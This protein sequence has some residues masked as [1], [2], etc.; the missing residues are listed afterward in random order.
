MI[1]EAIW[2]S[3]APQDFLRVDPRLASSREVNAILALIRFFPEMGSP[4]GGSVEVRRALVG[5]KRFFGL[6]YAFDAKR[7]IVLA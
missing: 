5:K 6:F 4:V 2:T 3:A 7:I 1:N